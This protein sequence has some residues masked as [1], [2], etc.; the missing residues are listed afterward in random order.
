MPAVMKLQHSLPLGLCFC[1]LTCLAQE[2][3]KEQPHSFPTYLK[4][5]QPT[6]PSVSR[7]LREQGVVMLSV[8]VNQLGSVEKV[9]LSRS[10]G[11]PRLDYAAAN[12]VER[13]TFVP[14]TRGNRTTSA[15]V[16]VPI[17]FILDDPYADSP[18]F[19]VSNCVGAREFGDQNMRPVYPQLSKQRNE[20]GR[21]VLRVHVDSSGEPEQVALESSSGFPL[22]DDAAI[23]AVQGWCFNPARKNGVT[24]ASWRSIPMTFRIKP[25]PA[26]GIT[27]RITLDAKKIFINISA[28]N[29]V[30]PGTQATLLFS[31]QPNG[32]LSNFGFEEKDGNGGFITYA[33]LAIKQGVSLP[34]SSAQDPTPYEVTATAAEW[35]IDAAAKPVAEKRSLKARVA[36]RNLWIEQVKNKVLKNIVVPENTPD[37]ARVKVSITQLPSAELFDIRIVSSNALPAYNDAVIKGVRKSAPLPTAPPDVFKSNIILS[38][39]PQ[40]ND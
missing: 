31:V 34:P 26:F 30:S 28:P 21:V 23:Q 25:D 8:L 12:A 39:S 19:K 32:T 4:N 10:S 6:Y 7:H 29:D 37:T 15:W 20:E 40:Q 24:E 17:S 38:I 22:L 33:I 14:A 1:V 36:D 2:P 16:Q 9:L 5:S 35:L 11:Y 27:Q 13:W 18:S 3:G